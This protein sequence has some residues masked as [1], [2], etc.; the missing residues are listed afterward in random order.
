MIE[1]KS[2]TMLPLA[3][4]GA[5]VGTGAGC[6]ASTKNI[7][8][9]TKMHAR[10]TLVGMHEYNIDSFIR[11]DARGNEILKQMD[12]FVK[13]DS[14]YMAIK[15]NIQQNKKSLRA[16]KHNKKTP[17]EFL[18]DALHLDKKVSTKK[19]ALRN[20]FLDT[21]EDKT[22]RAYFE[23][24]TKKALE[25]ETCQKSFKTVKQANKSVLKSK[26]KYIGKFA[27]I[28]IG[29]GALIGKGIDLIKNHKK[30]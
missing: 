17:M 7:D 11:Q 22:A 26:L 27:L 25:T 3:A 9:K 16:R 28:G 5:I 1:N 13:S 20:Q 15:G 8:L 14:E 19:A 12:E 29:A 23:D 2:N 21:C 24:L 4:A 10:N 6:I 30:A 18:T